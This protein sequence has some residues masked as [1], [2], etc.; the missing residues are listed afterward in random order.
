[1]PIPEDPGLL[2]FTHRG[3]VVASLALTPSEV[4]YLLNRAMN[5]WEPQDQPKG[6]LGFSDDV[7]LVALNK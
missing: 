1:M 3:Q 6:L 5:P 7:R 2:Q 4:C